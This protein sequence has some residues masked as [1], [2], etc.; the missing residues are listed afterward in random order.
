[1]PT[2]NQDV[3]DHGEASMEMLTSLGLQNIK[4]RFL[5]A[6]K[7]YEYYLLGKKMEMGILGL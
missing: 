3:E 2:E 1:M 6:K 5:P 4:V 7:V